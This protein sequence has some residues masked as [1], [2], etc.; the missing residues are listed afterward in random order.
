MLS[1]RFVVVAAAVLRISAQYSLPPA[2]QASLDSANITIG[3]LS[4]LT[5]A[6]TIVQTARV[7]N[8]KSG[9]PTDGTPPGLPQTPTMLTALDGML[10]VS[11]ISASN[12]TETPHSIG[13]RVLSN[14]DLV[15]N[16]TESRDAA[17]E[18]TAYLTYTVVSNASYSQ[19]RD[20]C[21]QFCDMTVG[22]E[23]VNL[24][25]EFN[26]PL[27]DFVF[28][29]KS[30]LKCVLYG[31]VHTAAEKTNF[32][33]QQLSPPPSWPTY[34]QQST[35]GARGYELVFG[36][37]S[38]ANSAPGYMGFAFID[39]YDPAACAKLCNAR[40]PDPA[41]GAC[42]Y[43]NIWRALV[44]G[45]PTTYTCSMYSAPTN[46]STAVN[47]GQGTLSV[48]LSRGYA[49]ISHV[50]DGGFEAYECPS[51]EPFCF[52][53]HTPEW[54]GTSPYAGLYDATVF[55]YASYAHGGTGVALL[56]SAYGA[57]P[58]PG[59]LVPNPPS[60]GS[61]TELEGPAFVEVWWNG[62]LTGSVR[63]GYSQ[64]TYFEFGVVAQGGGADVLLFKG[65]QAP[66]YDFLDDIYLFLA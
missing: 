27:L 56:G 31:D 2:L 40:D 10:M 3:V 26:D 60:R 9:A 20:E 18:G 49:R 42:K 30:N 8:Q 38:A 61:G 4:N 23:F 57:D 64:W 17:I 33:G 41:A 52:T 25:Y 28:Y 53:E 32:G 34:I 46:A 22:C 45:V 65:G 43:F 6:D 1:C 37:I 21:L 50:A 19:G 14:Y 66:A 63:V 59:T 36:P 13:G 5:D 47:T 12:S 58:L 24:Y 55:H 11:N 44:S 54:V 39:K 15:F 62:V 48:T 51:H 35:R 16:G 29:Q 7:V